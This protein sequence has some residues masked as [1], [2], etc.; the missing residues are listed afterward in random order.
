MTLAA[1]LPVLNGRPYCRTHQRYAPAD[2]ATCALCDLEEAAAAETIVRTS[3]YSGPCR[4]RRDLLE[5]AVC[6]RRL[7][8]DCF[9]RIDPYTGRPETPC[10]DC[11]A[12]RD[13]QVAAEVRAKYPPRQ[14]Q[15]VTVAAAPA[16]PVIKLAPVIN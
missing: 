14:A 1:P 10:R 8:S 16:V 15:V 13:Q 12:V 5:C 2:S 11:Q 4:R 6:E 7:R 9:R 3:S